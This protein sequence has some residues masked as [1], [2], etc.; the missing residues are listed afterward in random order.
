M[1][2]AWLPPRMAR[3]RV[4]AGPSLRVLAMAVLLFGVV[5][6]F[7]FGHGLHVESV[8]GHPATSAAEPVHEV[9]EEALDATDPQVLSRPAAMGKPDDGYGSSH[10]GQHC[11]SG[12]PPQGPVVTPPCFAVS[13][14]E[15]SAVG[16]A[17]AE[18]GLNEPVLSAASPM[19]LR[20]SV[21]Q[22]V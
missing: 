15:S 4:S 22:Q 9:A 10:P 2:T 8:E 13:V 5:I 20:M 19:S 18:R 1:I 14:G 21:V 16:P 3:A 17:S 12:Q 11:V 6:G 7:V